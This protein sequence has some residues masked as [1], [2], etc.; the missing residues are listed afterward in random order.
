MLIGLTPPKGCVAAGHFSETGAGHV[1]AADH[2]FQ[3]RH[4]VVWPLRSAEGNHDQGVVGGRRGKAE[5]GRP[6][7]G[8]SIERW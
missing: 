1:L 5:G 4:Y 8:E 2:V 6:E 7:F 3:E